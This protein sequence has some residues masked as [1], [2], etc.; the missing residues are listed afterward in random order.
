MNNVM[1]GAGAAWQAA[2]V[3]V[4]V[5]L[6]SWHATGVLSSASFGPDM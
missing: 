2:L 4:V 6:A 3:A 1:H 5:C